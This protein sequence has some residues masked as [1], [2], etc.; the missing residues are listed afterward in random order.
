[1]SVEAVN[2]RNQFRGVVREIIP[3]PVVS[4]VLV[5]TPHGVVASVITSR[6]VDELKLGI[7]SPVLAVVRATEVSLTR[8]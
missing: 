4:E 6:A 5:E 8:V 3:G 7:G 2:A 1:M